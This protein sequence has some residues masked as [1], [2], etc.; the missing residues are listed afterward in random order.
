[1]LLNRFQPFSERAIQGARFSW[2]D[3]SIGDLGQDS[4]LKHPDLVQAHLLDLSYPRLN[5]GFY[6]RRL[7]FAHGLLPGGRDIESWTPAALNQDAYIAG[8]ADM[9]SPCAGTAPLCL[10][11]G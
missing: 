11:A 10:R 3:T 5:I 7:S 6:F 2:L 9:H 1:L 4:A 8:I